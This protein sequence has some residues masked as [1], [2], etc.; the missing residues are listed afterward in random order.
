MTIMSNYMPF[1]YVLKRN[2]RRIYE[3]EKQGKNGKC[4]LGK[5]SRIDCDQ[6]IPLGIAPGEINQLIILV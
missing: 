5:Y 3:N 2:N 4:H 1:M 6:S